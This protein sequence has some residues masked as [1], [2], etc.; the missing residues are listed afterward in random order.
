MK[1]VY[2]VKATTNQGEESYKIGVTK[3]DPQKRIKQLQT[4][5]PSELTLIDTYYSKF[6]TTIESYLHRT[7]AMNKI[8]G[9]WF[10]LDKEQIELFQEQCKKL[11]TNL[12]MIQEDNTW[13]ESLKKKNFY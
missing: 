10:S 5:N 3:N 8:K 12:K 9:E 7:Y 1:Y 11:E 6:G 13:Y 2:L 4:G